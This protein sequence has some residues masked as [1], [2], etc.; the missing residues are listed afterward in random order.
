MQVQ[1]FR[2]SV[3]RTFRFPHDDAQRRE[4]LCIMTLGLAG[5]A[6]EVAD[7]IKKLVGHGKH[8]TRDA[9][10]KELG[11][12]L[13]YLDRVAWFFD[14]DLSEVME[15]NV[16]KLNERYPNGFKRQDES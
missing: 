12:V 6:G 1:E 9:I 15:T 16:A 11:D 8:V 5:E 14:L 2:E 7:E 3:E 4:L 10:C 13:W